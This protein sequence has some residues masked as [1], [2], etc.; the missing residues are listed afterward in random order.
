MVTDCESRTYPPDEDLENYITAGPQE[1]DHAE[2]ILLGKL[3]NLMDK[4][5]K[6]NCKTVVL[7]TW[8]LPCEEC[9]AEIIEKLSPLAKE[10]KQVILV[11]TH[12]QKP[13]VSEKDEDRVVREIEETKILVLKERCYTRISPKTQDRGC[14]C[15]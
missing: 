2:A 14:L 10:G 9:K 7:Y 11:Y 15:T 1:S 3:N 8:L 13:K 5:G 4:F 6:D 12:R